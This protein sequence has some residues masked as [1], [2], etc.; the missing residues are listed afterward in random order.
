VLSKRKDTMNRNAI[1]FLKRH[2]ITLLQSAAQAS[3]HSRTLLLK[4]SSHWRLTSSRKAITRWQRA[5]RDRSL[6]RAWLAR[7]DLHFRDTALRTSLTLLHSQA[8]HSQ[9]RR[10]LNEKAFDFLFYSV[11]RPLFAAWKQWYESRMKAVSLAEDKWECRLRIMLTH[12]FTCWRMT[13]HTRRKTYHVFRAKVVRRVWAQHFNLW[14]HVHTV[15][16]KGRVICEK[17]NTKIMRWCLSY[18]QNVFIAECNDKVL[19]LHAYR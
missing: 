14:R 5:V 12:T 19:N 10:A 15:K 7:A 17:R 3:I 4:A 11:A 1:L 18:W 13:A 2:W 6:H 16:K 8:K 9:Y